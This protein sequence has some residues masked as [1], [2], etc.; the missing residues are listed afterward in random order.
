MKPKWPELKPK[1][2]YEGSENPGSEDQSSMK[3]NLKI[4]NCIPIK[5]LGAD[6][7]GVPSK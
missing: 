3:T 1:L 5:V 7:K 4:T 2:A 6:A